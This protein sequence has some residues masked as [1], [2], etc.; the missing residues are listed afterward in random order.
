MRVV[1]IKKFCKGHLMNSITELYIMVNGLKMVIEME[2]ELKFGKMGVNLLVIGEMTKLT[3]KEDSF[4][5]MVTFMKEIGLTIKLKE[6]EPMSIWTVLNTWVNGEKIVNTDME[7]RVGQI[8]Q[9]MKVITST[10]R[11][12]ASVLSNGVTDHLTSVNF[13][14]I[15]FMVKVCIHGQTTEFTKVNGGQIKCMGKELLHGLTGVNM[16]ENMLK[17]K[18]EDMENSFGLMV[19][20]TEANG[21]MESN[22]EKE[23]T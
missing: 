7:S 22:T 18:N 6:E 21:S 11:N 10:V 13:T 23:H 20:A 17:T 8:M 9:N 2:K 14:I 3:V 16:L 4:M 5:L 1:E 19:D 12:M 15:I